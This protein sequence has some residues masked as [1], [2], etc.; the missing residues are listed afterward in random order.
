MILDLS[1]FSILFALDIGSIVSVIFV[2]SVVDWQCFIIQFRG[3]LFF[4]SA[5]YFL[6]FPLTLAFFFIALIAWGIFIIKLVLFLTLIFGCL[7]FHTWFRLFHFLFI[8]MD[9]VLNMIFINGFRFNWLVQV[10][11]CGWDDSHY[12]S[13]FIICF[14][15]SSWNL[16]LSNFDLRLSASKTY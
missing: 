14:L 4:I 12:L 8:F 15:F 5:W 9:K 10:F 1:D 6:L 11:Q 16:I 13:L 7:L 3:F 2:L